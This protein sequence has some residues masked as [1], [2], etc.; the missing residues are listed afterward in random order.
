M[1]WFTNCSQSIE[2]EAFDDVWNGTCWASY[3]ATYFGLPFLSYIIH[4]CFQHYLIILLQ[5]LGHFLWAQTN[6]AKSGPFHSATAYLIFHYASPITVAKAP[7]PWQQHT[8]NSAKPFPPEYT[9]ESSPLLGFFCAHLQQP[10]LQPILWATTLTFYLTPNPYASY[11]LVSD[12]RSPSLAPLGFS[13]V[14]RFVLDDIHPF[15]TYWFG[16]LHL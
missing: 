14:V 1:G 7:P 5:P 8:F 4:H 3:V 15:L 16:C 6:S 10:A 2:I 11:V 9:R 13:L 12:S